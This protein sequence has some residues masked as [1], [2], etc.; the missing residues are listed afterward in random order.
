M[1]KNRI[2]LYIKRLQKLDNQISDESDPIN[3]MTELNNIINGLTNEIQ[4]DTRKKSLS[5][6]LKFINT[7]QNPDPKFIDESDIGFDIYA[8]LTKDVVINKGE[9]GLIPTGL[10]FEA[11][12]GLEVQIRSRN[13]LAYCGV[14][15][16]NSSGAVDPLS[17]REIKV[18]LA[19]FGF[20]DFSIK[21]GDRIAQGV[22]CPVYG[23]ENLNLV[24]VKKLSNT[25]NNNNDFGSTDAK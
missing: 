4:F 1:E 19:N 18:I 6:T 24:K 8:N 20:E 17:Q 12:K 2:E 15:V 5:T 11:D 14:I 23:K 22:V 16:L 10:Y 21:H 7:S 13:A 25:E 3:L 9:I